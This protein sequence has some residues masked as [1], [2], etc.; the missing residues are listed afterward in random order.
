MDQY[1]SVWLHTVHVFIHM[2]F[3][4]HLHVYIYIYFFIDLYMYTSVCVCIY[5]YIYRYLRHTRSK[6]ICIKRVCLGFGRLYMRSQVFHECQ[7]LN[8]K[9]GFRVR[10]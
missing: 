1:A 6:Y 9:A 4:K 3:L 2:F 8:F 10:D 7:P 5:I